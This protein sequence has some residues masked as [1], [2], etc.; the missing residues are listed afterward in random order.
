MIDIKNLI[1]S[2]FSN[3]HFDAPSHTYTVNGKNLI[4]VS[5]YIE[6]YKKEFDIELTS[7]RY[8]E[9]RNLLQDDVKKEWRDKA[10]IACELGT[11]VHAFGESYFSDKTLTYRDGYEE[12]IIR[13]WNSLP[14][15]WIPIFSE[16]RVYSEKYM[17]AGTVDNLFY[18]TVYDKIIITDYKTNADLHS[19]FADNRLK[20]PFH[21]LQDTSFHLY[22]LQLSMYQIP[23]EDIGVSVSNRYVIWLKPNGDFEQIPTKDYTKQLRRTLTLQ[24]QR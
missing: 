11:R 15:T 17:F 5:A 9:K 4:S 10:T 18:D 7:K 6:K 1:Q 20:S 12:A 2:I 19:N 24:Q 16:C 23:L 22:E 21:F 3:L 13:F 8:A 14:S